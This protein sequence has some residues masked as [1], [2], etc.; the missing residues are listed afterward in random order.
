MDLFDYNTNESFEPENTV[1]GNR[2]LNNIIMLSIR[3]KKKKE[4]K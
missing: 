3:I 2:R 1:G 4:A